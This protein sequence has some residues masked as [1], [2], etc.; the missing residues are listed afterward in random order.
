MPV[1]ADPHCLESL[2]LIETV[3]R[4]R[5]ADVSDAAKSE[6]AKIRAFA[7][8]GP[9]SSGQRPL[10]GVRFGEGH[11]AARVQPDLGSSHGDAVRLGVLLISVLCNVV[12]VLFSVL[13][14]L[15][16][17]VLMEELA[18]ISMFIDDNRKFVN[19]AERRLF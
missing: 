19:H 14:F 13:W 2:G 3:K 9:D 8:L 1:T 17:C 6:L 12:K 7:T 4:Y 15:I 10:S 18:V 16:W 11:Y 5:S